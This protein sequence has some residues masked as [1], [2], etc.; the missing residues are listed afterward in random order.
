MGAVQRKIVGVLGPAQGEAVIRTPDMGPAERTEQTLGDTHAFDPVDSRV[1]A[2][3]L[4]ASGDRV[5][6]APQAQ[7]GDTELFQGQVGLFEKYA[8]VI[9]TAIMGQIDGPQTEGALRGGRTG[10]I[11][12]AHQGRVL[13]FKMQVEQV[14]LPF[15]AQ[16]GHGG[17]I[18]IR[19]IARGAL[20]PIPELAPR[21]QATEDGQLWGN[22]A[23]RDVRSKRSRKYSQEQQGGQQKTYT[24]E[25]RS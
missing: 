12:Q 21:A 18:G 16:L 2:H 24:V 19:R 6:S 10:V 20:K 14:L 22:L 11:G 23:D 25:T 4:R 15:Q 3:H 13:G 7:A 5:S 8:G 1:L 17:R 9:P